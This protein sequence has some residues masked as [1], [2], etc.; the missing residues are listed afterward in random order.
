VRD[1]VKA[2]RVEGYEI[3]TLEDLK[4]AYEVLA[5]EEAAIT[6]EEWTHV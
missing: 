6:E 5:T 4:E 1:L 3:E 2:N